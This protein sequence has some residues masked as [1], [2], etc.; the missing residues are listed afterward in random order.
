MPWTSED[1]KRHS[2]KMNTPARK[3]KWSAIANA[4]LKSSGNEGKAIRI[5][6]SKAYSKGGGVAIKGHGKGA[7]R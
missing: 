2:K 1:A 3:K 7:I 6:N 4:V 5:A